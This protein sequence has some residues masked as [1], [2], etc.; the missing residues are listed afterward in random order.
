MS[1]FIRKVGTDG[2]RIHHQATL[3]KSSPTKNRASLDEETEV[4]PDP[5]A[6]RDR[7]RPRRQRS[8][9]PVPGRQRRHSGHPRLILDWRPRS[10]VGER[11]DRRPHRAMD[12]RAGR[13]PR[14]CPASLIWC[15]KKPG[16]ELPRRCRASARLAAGHEVAERTGRRIRPYRPRRQT[17]VKDER[18]PRARCGAIRTSSC[19]TPASN[20]SR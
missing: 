10:R 12:S 19:P 3:K 7:D 18:R 11:G 16:R 4:K 14:L 9:R 13:S 1:Y 20:G 15:A 6:D 8:G 17:R 2:F 5:Q